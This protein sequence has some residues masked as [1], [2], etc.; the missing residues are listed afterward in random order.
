M[1]EESEGRRQLGSTMGYG[2][3]RTDKLFT[4][5]SGLDPDSNIAAVKRQILEPAIIAACARCI[6]KAQVSEVLRVIAYEPVQVEFGGFLRICK[7]IESV[8]EGDFEDFIDD[9]IDVPDNLESTEER[10]I[11]ALGNAIQAGK[12]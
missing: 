9:L 2:R 5:F 8:I 10:R 1:L 3:D 11:G 7:T 6:P 12:L 4:A